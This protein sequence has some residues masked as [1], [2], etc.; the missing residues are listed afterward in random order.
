MPNPLVSYIIPTFNAERYLK[1]CLDSIFMQD[2]P[3]DKYEVIVADGGSNDRTIEILKS[4]PVIYVHNE[5]RDAESGKYVAI[6]KAK[7]DIYVLLDA[8]NIIASED[9]LTS[10][11]QPLKENPNIIGVESNYLIA[12]DFTSI[13]TYA[14]LLVIVDPLAR[15]LAAQPSKIEK[16]STYILKTFAQDSTPVS[17]ANGFLWRKSAVE[18]FLHTNGR[19]FPE[20]KVLA[21]AAARGEVVYANVPGQGIYHYYCVSLR[22]Y[23]MKREKIAKKIIERKSRHEEIWIDIAGKRRLY[24]SAVYIVSLIGPLLEATWNFLKTGRKEWFWH[25]AISFLTV[26]VYVKG[27]VYGKRLLNQQYTYVA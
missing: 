7:G 19:E 17:G 22:D 8:D 23:L 6:Q 14:N 9:W 12:D 16:K 15:M 10:L 21:E 2:Y 3:R 13:N 27:T 4:Y 20:V 1:R 18:R 11:I 5:K 25:P 24:F 26:W